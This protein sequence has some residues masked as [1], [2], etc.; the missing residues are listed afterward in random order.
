MII[1]AIAF[2]DR[3]AKPIAAT[4]S[5][6]QRLNE[7]VMLVHVLPKSTDVG[8][9]EGE[10]RGRAIDRLVGIADQLRVD[11]IDV[12]PEL[13]DGTIVEALHACAS[14]L[15]PS[16]MIMGG[17]DGEPYRGTNHVADRLSR[18]LPC[19]FL[20]TGAVG[21]IVNGAPVAERLRAIVALDSTSA[22]DAAIAEL[23][24]LRSA[25]PLDCDVVTF[26]WPPD[27]QKR[28]GLPRSLALEPDPVA[29]GILVGE[30][31]ARL[32]DLPGQGEVTVT[33][34]PMLAPLGLLLPAEA[35]KRGADMVLVGSHQRGPIS[36]FL[37]ASVTQQLLRDCEVPVLF[38]P[39]KAKEPRGR[40]S[41][42]RRVLVATDLSDFGNRAIAYAYSYLRLVDASVEIMHVMT[43][44]SESKL[45]GMV[46]QSLRF[47]S[48]PAE[49][50]AQLLQELVPEG[51]EA[52]DLSCSIHIERGEDVARHIVDR[53]RLIG[54]EAICIAGHGAG[55]VCNTLGL[56]I[57]NDVIHLADRPVLVVR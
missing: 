57:V 2:D 35:R 27:E 10:R 44:A 50:A 36:G 40:V 8:I 9:D 4:R 42:P 39:L 23:R 38:A 45:R 31:R 21:A 41:E 37:H 46:L 48:P 47:L 29:E 1:T 34:M 43:T 12:Q 30:L 5:L 49:L 13:L 14:R 20:V 16:L 11:G 33:A 32:G 15:R 56:S 19:P 7:P 52:Y 26:Y 17:R 53:A 51:G 28:L 22:S 55:R 18:R 3:D 54:A 24:E 6:A 25:L